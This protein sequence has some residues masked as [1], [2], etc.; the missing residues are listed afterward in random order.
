MAENNP[1]QILS[2]PVMQRRKILGMVVPAL[3]IP[4][5]LWNGYQV[6]LKVQQGMSFNSFDFVEELILIATA[7]VFTL[8]IPKMLPVYESKYWM[9]KDGIEITRLMMSKTAIPYKSIER[10]EI[11]IR[12]SEEISD[13]AR[14]YA[15]DASATL[16]KAGFKFKDYTNA[17]AKIMNIFVGQN[18]YMLSPDK[19]KNLVKE[20]KRRNKKITAKIVELTKRGTKIQE[21]GKT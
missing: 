1:E 16:R 21:L 18:I 10:V 4:L 20:L 15:M 9:G 11:Y 3:N 14:Q 5:L 7:L 13:E 12:Q 8:M 19:P 2:L 6:I 17:E